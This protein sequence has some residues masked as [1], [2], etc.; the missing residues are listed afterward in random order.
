MASVSA[1]PVSSGSY[2]AARAVPAGSTAHA[3]VQCFTTFADSIAFATAGRVH[4]A[5]AANAR[6]VTAAELKPASPATNYVLSIDYMDANFSGAT[7]T[8][9]QSSPCGNYQ[10][11]SMP[12]GWNDDISSVAA[13]SSCATTLFWNINFGQPTYLIHVDGSAGSLG[14]FNDQTSSQKWC[15]TYPCG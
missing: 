5:N 12:S 8:W 7:F 4:L 6:L 15:H 1:A 14:S 13:Y 10:T 2:C 11:A 3:Q 9:Y